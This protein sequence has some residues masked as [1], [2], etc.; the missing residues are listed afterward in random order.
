MSLV[1]AVVDEAAAER[2]VADV[3]LAVALGSAGHDHVELDAGREGGRLT[4]RRGL[5]G[6]LLDLGQPIVG[7][8]G[9][10]HGSV[11]L[12]VGHCTWAAR[13]WGPAAG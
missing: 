9:V 7:Q 2:A 13:S 3:Q 5:V 11:L 10:R 8:E 12:F 6:Q 1:G 4:G